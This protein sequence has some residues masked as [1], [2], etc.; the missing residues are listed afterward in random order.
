[1][2]FGA[3]LISNTWQAVIVGWIVGGILGYFNRNL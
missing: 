2:G 3:V 1:M